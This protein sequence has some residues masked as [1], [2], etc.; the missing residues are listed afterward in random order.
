MK[1]KPNVFFLDN[2]D[3]FVFNLVDEF[4]RRG[5]N[6]QVWRNTISVERA[7]DILSIMP[8]PKLLVISPGPGSPG[9]AGCSV[10]LIRRLPEEIPML[11]V[12]LGH[13]ALIEACGGLVGSAGQIVHGK[14]SLLIH[15]GTGLFENIPSPM[16][17]GRYHSL[18]ARQ[19]PASLRVTASLD[20]IV[21]AVEHESRPLWGVQFHPESIL[22][23]HGGRL[24]E[25]VL[26]RV[27]A[28][29]KEVQHA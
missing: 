23:P 16:M 9:D 29:V 11:G 25:N 10:D 1:I 24:L 27:V 20:G 8:E 3:S 15:S 14:S 22:T 4:A 17:I 6:V 21:M 13:Q 7:L 28:P 2:V 26:R 19:I 18:S 12:C 5:C